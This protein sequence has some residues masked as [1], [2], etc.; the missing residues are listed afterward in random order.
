MVE[1]PPRGLRSQ[2]M[3]VRQQGLA[4]AG[5]TLAVRLGNCGG[6]YPLST[7]IRWLRRDRSSADL[8]VSPQEL[9][10]K[11]W[12]DAEDF[13][14]DNSREGKGSRDETEA[15]SQSQRVSRPKR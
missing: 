6:A 1:G 8:S 13:V 14:T 3:A 12:V 11:L 15:P 5:S 10:S 7:Q 4:V 9:R 2:V